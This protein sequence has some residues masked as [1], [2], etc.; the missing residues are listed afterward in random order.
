MIHYH[1]IDVNFYIMVVQTRPIKNRLPKKYYGNLNKLNYIVIFNVN[2]H[3]Q[4]FR[5]PVQLFDQ[6]PLLIYLSSLTM[7]HQTS[8]NHVP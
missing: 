8:V 5:N 4:I 2:S 7:T 1:R 6:I 3:L